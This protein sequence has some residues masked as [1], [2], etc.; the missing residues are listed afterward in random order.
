MSG[1]PVVLER[2]TTPRGELA[3]RRVGEHFEIISN[4]TFLMDTRSGR[5]ERLLVTAATSRHPSPERVLIAGLGVGFSLLAALADDRATRVVVVEVESVLVAWHGTHLAPLTST[6]FADPRAEI[7]M[8]D[9]LDHLRSTDERYDVICL[10]I[11]NGPDWTVTAANRAL[12]D[13]A[14]TALLASRLAS[15]GVL[16]VWSAAR[17]PAYE[18]VL[19][20]SFE[21]VETERVEIARGEP[22]IVMVGIGPRGVRRRDDN[23]DC[24]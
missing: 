23:H 7:V 20:E 8:A 5:S 17:S 10:D 9:L 2:V 13:A 1:Q 14:G 24:S 4:G 19:A 16:S 15:G 18:A 11:D 3:L 21:R 12:Y 22:D 6:A